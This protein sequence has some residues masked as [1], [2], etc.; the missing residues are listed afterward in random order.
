MQS[1]GKRLVSL[2]ILFY[3]ACMFFGL[4]SFLRCFP[5]I[6]IMLKNPAMREFLFPPFCSAFIL[7]EKLTACVQVFIM[8]MMLLLTKNFVI[9]CMCTAKNTKEIGLFV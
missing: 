2:A 9:L 4:I 5:N 6:T 3:V 8:L 1:E 7:L